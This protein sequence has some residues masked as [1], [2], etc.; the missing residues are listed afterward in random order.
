M[1]RKSKKI[2]LLDTAKS[3]LD[4][5]NILYLVF[6]IFTFNILDAVLTMVWLKAGY[7]EEMNPLMAE[8]L[9]YGNVEFLITKIILV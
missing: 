7:A 5:F 6:F 1:S 9:E 8:A 2:Q 4:K 3:F